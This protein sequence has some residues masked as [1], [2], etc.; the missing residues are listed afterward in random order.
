M[1]EKG[2]KAISKVIDELPLDDKVIM[3]DV[4]DLLDSGLTGDYSN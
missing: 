3:V 1:K 2:V 4:S